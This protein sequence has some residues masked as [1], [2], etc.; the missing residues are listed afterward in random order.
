MLALFELI[1]QVCLGRVI[2]LIALKCECS[3]FGME[4]YALYK[5]PPLVVFA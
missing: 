3:W 1:S 5:Y 2:G 4:L